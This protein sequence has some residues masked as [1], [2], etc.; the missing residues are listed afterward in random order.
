MTAKREAIFAALET[1][2]GTIPGIASVERMAPGEPSEFPAIM[3]EDVGQQRIPGEVGSSRYALQAV[4]EAY[5][6]GEVN[7]HGQLNEIY[8]EVVKAI[9]AEPPLGGLVDEINEGG[10][11][12]AVATLASKRRLGFALDIEIEFSAD[13][14]NPSV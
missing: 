12:V 5:V 7:A 14:E 3:I 6:V 11:R 4:V 8:V 10:L 1:V 13:R 9:T 2:L